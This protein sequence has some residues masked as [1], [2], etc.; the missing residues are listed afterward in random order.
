MIPGGPLPPGNRGYLWE[1]ARIVASRGAVVFTADYRSSP[2]Y[3]GG[4]PATFAD[5]AC[6][7]RFAR[8]KAPE[9]GGDAGRVTL[10]GHSFGG[11]PAAVVALSAHDFATDEPACLASR[12]DGHPDALAGIAGVY[13][14]DRIGQDFL[15]TFFGG[16]RASAPDAWAAGDVTALVRQTG[17]PAPPV[18]LLAGT[19]D[20]VAPPTTMAE[21]ADLLRAAGYDVT[22]TTLDGATHDTILQKLATVDAIARLAGATGQ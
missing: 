6:A 13:T 14:L 8:Q 22:A 4:Y 16:D 5:V 2:A 19:S 9:L 10:V 11:F 3:G 15:A 20:P 21:F 18:R 17:R 7:V 12:G 1:L